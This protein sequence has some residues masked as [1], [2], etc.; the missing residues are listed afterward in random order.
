MCQQFTK[1]RQVG[2]QA[3]AW[4]SSKEPDRLKKICEKAEYQ[5]KTRGK[6][7]RSQN[8]KQWNGLLCETKGCTKRKRC[9]F[10][11]LFKF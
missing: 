5:P 8:W 10:F 2:N 11:H 1:K 4:C 3:I 6:I 9:F 7:Q